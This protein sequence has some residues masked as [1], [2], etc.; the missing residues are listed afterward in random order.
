MAKELFVSSTPHET[1]VA[2]AEDDLLAEVY[3]ER[4]NEYTLAG[5]IYKGR[6]TRVLP[7]MQSAF[8]N[9]GLERDAFLY[10]S[11]FL[12]EEEDD[13]EALEQVITRS[14]VEAPEPEMRM[15]TQPGPIEAEEII[16]P[17]RPHA[18]EQG[19]EP[20][21]AGSESE[22]GPGEGDR[23]GTRQWRGRRRR[24]RGRF[25][26][27]GPERINDRPAERGANRSNE[28]GEH[29]SRPVNHV[30]P[31]AEARP[32]PP[33]HAP[34]HTQAHGGYEPIVLPGESLSK[35]QPHSATPAPPKPQV[36]AQPASQYRSKPSTEYSVDS[37]RFA[38]GSMVLPGESISKYRNED[39]ATHVPVARTQEHTA[40]E[41]ELQPP[42][43][44][45]E[46]E[47]VK[48]E[49]LEEEPRQR[50]SYAI[51]H[52]LGYTATAQEPEEEVEAREHHT[53]SASTAS[54]QTH[55]D[56]KTGHVAEE[57]ER[58][59]LEQMNVAS[60]FGGGAV[61]TPEETEEAEVPH[62]AE[63]HEPARSRNQK[64]KLYGAQ[65]PGSPIRAGVARG[66]VEVP[67][68]A[69]EKSVQADKI[70]IKTKTD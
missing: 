47:G 33:I 55:L 10:V 68:A 69:T 28:R 70:S 36:P 50:A 16:P 63:E 30:E 12:L 58:E 42:V 6:V 3:Y 57:Q 11:D 25:Q 4:E 62:F 19:E 17:A 38:P 61:E 2:I 45:A 35:Y 65:L 51:R 60:V 32:Q 21:A 41:E 64:E 34:V 54:E 18:H 49:H 56:R 26:E 1:K 46:P 7:G 53:E 14:R 39:R 24:G 29:E 37:S 59:R 48:P 23:E 31:A 40:V 9:V 5:S 67:S 15:E 66:G 44:T 43:T 22:S 20:F 27:R 13:A 8:V 52:D